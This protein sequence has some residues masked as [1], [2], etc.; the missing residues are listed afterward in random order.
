MNEKRKNVM[1]QL[2][3]VVNMV[4]GMDAEELDLDADL[5][6]F[7]LDSLSLMALGKQI[8][9]KFNI[10]ISLEELVT[11]YNTLSLIGDYLNEIIDLPEVEG[12]KEET[13][14]EQV[15]LE[16]ASKTAVPVPEMTA[17]EIMESDKIAA[18]QMIEQPISV[19]QS[20]SW[21]GN[22]NISAVNQLF[23][24]QMAIMQEQTSIIKQ[25]LGGS[26]PY[27][28]TG[29]A[30]PVVKQKEQKTETKKTQ[31]KQATPVQN[32]K[33]DYYV[34]Y[35]K[36]NTQ[37]KADITESQL[38][39]IKGHE[40]SYTSL[41][42]NSKQVTSDYRKIHAEWRNASGFSTLYKEYVYPIYAKSGKGSKVTDIDN[43]EFIDVAMGFGVNLFGNNP[44]FVQDAV[45]NAM[46]EN[47]TPL[48]PLDKV[49]C[50]V[51]EKIT[52]LTGV[53]RVFF[54][55]TG[56]E[57]DMFAV[58]IARAVTGKNKV[59]CFKGS[60]HGGYD[61]LLGISFMNEQGEVSTIPMAPGITE[62]AVSD[63]IMLEYNSEESIKYIESHADSIA[64]VMVEPVQSRRPDI[65]PKEFLKKLRKI[66]K[67]KNMAL[68]F[69]EVVLGFRIA[70]GG[71]QEYFGVEADIVTYGKVVG[72]GLPI[73]IIAGNSR[74]MDSIDGGKWTYGDDSVPVNS[75]T[76]TFVGGTFCHNHYTISAANAV[77]D[78][79]LANKDSMYDTLNRKTEYLVDTL[80]KFL[81][82]EKV[83]ITIY[84]FCSMFK[85][86]LSANEDIFYYRLL[87][88]GVYIWEGRTCFLSTEHSD[89]DV[90]KIIAAVKETVLEMKQANFFDNENSLVKKGEKKKLMSLIQQRLFSQIEVTGH[91]PFDMVG[92]FEVCGTLDTARFEDAMNQVIKKNDVLRTRL[93]M[94]NGQFIQKIEDELEIKIRHV[95]Q[96]T[97]G[98][99][100]AYINQILCKF[101]LDQLPLIE[102]IN[103]KTY[104]AKEIL[105]F[106]IH[107]A[108]S[109]GISLEII[110]QETLKAL[111]GGELETIRPYHEFVKW[112]EEYMNSEELA[113]DKEF[114]S[115]EL[116]E[117][118][119]SIPLRYKKN[120]SA[121][122]NF[123]G[124]VIYDFIQEDAANKL[125]QIAKDNGVSM[126]MLMLG[127]LDIMLHK[128]THVD[129]I[130]I[131]ISAS[132]RFV[133]GFDNALGMFANNIAVKSDYQK[134]MSLKDYLKTIKEH[135]VKSFS[136][137]SF[138]YNLL[139]KEVQS[140]GQ[141]EFNVTFSYENADERTPEVDGVEFRPISFMTDTQDYEVTFDLQEKNGGIE[142][143][144]SYCKDLFNEKDMN[145]MLERYL[146]LTRQIIDNPECRLEDLD[147]L[148]DDER[149]LILGAFNQTEVDFPREETVVS[150][151]EKQV[152]KTPDAIALWDYDRKFTYKE[153]NEKAN[154]VARHLKEYGVGANNAV[155]LMALRSAETIICIHGILKAGA[156]YMPVDPRV[157]K[158]RV[159][160]M[161]K[162]CNPKLILAGNMDVPEGLGVPVRSI[163]DETLYT[164]DSENLNTP[165]QPDNIVHYMYTSGTTGNPK[166]VMNTHV[167]LLNRIIWQQKE[168]PMK[169]GDS[170]LQKTTYTFDDSVYEV[171]WST[172]V[173]ATL[174]ILEPGSEMDVEQMYEAVKLYSITHILFVPTVAREFL[175]YVKIKN[176]KK[177]ISTLK[178]MVTSGEALTPDLVAL[179]KEILGETEC[180]LANLYGPTEASIDV[181]YYNCTLEETGDIPIGKPI[182]NTT[183]YIL[184]GEELCGI[185][186][187]GEL[188]IGGIGV[189]KGYLNRPELTQEKFI[190]NPFG[191]GTLYRTGDVAYWG[192]DGNVEFCGRADD[193][194]KVRG[195][196]IELGEVEAAIRKL[197]GIDNA[198]VLG[199]K[200]EKHVESIYCY[201]VSS[202]TLD[203]KNIREQLRVTLPDYMIPQYMMQID[204]IPVA[205]NGKVRK[206]EL[207]EIKGESNT[208][209]VA[210]ENEIQKILCDI[211]QDVLGVE[212]V[213]IQDGFYELG[214]DS[215]RAIKIVSK[216]REAGYELAVKEIF[217]RDT[218]ESVSMAVKGA[219]AQNAVGSIMPLP[220]MNEFE[221]LG[222]DKAERYNYGI[223]VPVGSAGEKI[224]KDAFEKLMEYHDILRAVYEQGVLN[225]LPKDSIQVEMKAIDLRGKENA[226]VVMEQECIKVRESIQL[227]HGPLAKGLFFQMDTGNY[228]M[229]C[230]HH[231]VAD[232]YS[233]QI[234]LEDYQALVGMLEDGETPVLEK[235]TIS[236]KEY[237]EV[238]DQY[239]N[240]E[241]FKADKEQWELTK[242]RIAEAKLEGI[243]PAT[244][245][246]RQKKLSFTLPMSET[247][248]LLHSAGM[249]FNTTVS[250]LL[251]VALAKACNCLTGQKQIAL[252]MEDLGRDC[253]P[254]VHLERTV[255]WVSSHYPVCIDIEES[256]EDMII[257]TKEQIHK[258][259]EVKAG[260]SLVCKETR[261][262]ILLDCIEVDSQ[263]G[264]AMHTDF[265][266]GSSAAKEYKSAFALE[267]HFS[268]QNQ[269]LNAVMLYDET[270]M[271]DV[272][273]EQL[274]NYLE[275]Q[276]HEE[277]QFCT[278]REKSVK[279]ASD[280][281]SLDMEN[282][283]I[284]EILGMF[285]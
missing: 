138:P 1:N 190:P 241:T 81:K 257:N 20:A 36:T 7:G 277:I 2:F 91:D 84:N 11:K 12:I 267:I 162:D 271:E 200:D 221:A 150:M 158:E 202:T 248:E 244:T 103:V 148:L 129:S 134:S 95:V 246:Y 105:V 71:A 173:G 216:L 172:M 132:L 142:I 157:P 107:H 170:I 193:Q 255:G 57:A 65:Q 259:P 186:M 161:V 201:L 195:Q 240:Q 152:E 194:V 220:V 3:E 282:A 108:V 207:P 265:P 69:D 19:T 90:E 191:E 27:Q 58:R 243:K 143:N 153:M 213:G 133:S 175:R 218:L 76:R 8:G 98:D 83:P 279:T 28:A 32:T 210:P 54:S 66:T 67:E 102:V 26:K 85:F 100:N 198:V 121:Q 249:A 45:R 139:L 182:D 117:V 149:E 87:Q 171:L 118:T 165:I 274:R 34:P 256:M 123:E 53:E 169:P 4:T 122:T 247:D 179:F 10:D 273:A 260:A 112:E 92:V 22:E 41:T 225:V 219:A 33:G 266:T 70:P 235:Q 184:Q 204:K 43:N 13:S 188:C 238:F 77:M 168:Y 101:S 38:E 214:G 79:I 196:R 42:K 276:I 80:N 163:Y 189:A 263:A 252:E 174:C 227:E 127:T 64:A 74:F 178:M 97:D 115:R 229:I 258:L 94:E 222:L 16:E 128:I 93:C 156:A 31:Q 113:A 217:T 183:I 278:K 99:L 52:K 245:E 60:Y 285:E 197:D 124:T 111:G 78:Y 212:R 155:C 96:E 116:E 137:S 215:I 14:E 30:M 251:L 89:E 106:H 136:H 125:K 159:S 40:E 264:A 284:D 232:K 5:F 109:D 141:D 49:A 55:N 72:G 119:C 147:V 280:Y 114:W 164:G 135:T 35:K 21:E 145:Y 192:H 262:D 209:Y 140:Q 9:K 166:G 37:K 24:K 203:L 151:F 224:A 272:K 39:Y 131:A 208:V 231:L 61:G 68:I 206:R 160:Y 261:A 167:G 253:L 104:S 270:R 50:E 250:E 281:G 17:L 283:E 82:E 199:R 228:V 75:A 46:L 205:S 146:K 56:T 237:S 130:A 223:M 120:K 181:T 254:G 62:N 86:N 110:V 29:Q 126:F 226:L 144:F 51:A 187:P 44:D 154:Q 18:T 48:G 230:V 242:N 239:V 73:G 177:D 269:I 233:L 180:V 176:A 15:I 236:Y 25:L 275:Q 47:G 268:V 211:Y 59:V 6:S 88:K 63:L 234:L 23:I 185:G